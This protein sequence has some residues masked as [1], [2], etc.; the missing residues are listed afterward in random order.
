VKRDDF[1]SLPLRIALGIIYDIAR[2]PKL[3]DMPRPDV[4]KPPLYDTKL[5][6]GGGGFVWMS[7]MA[8]A[9]LEWWRNTKQKSADGNGD[10]ADRDRKSVAT[11]EKWI[12]WRVCFPSDTWSG[13]RGEDRVSGAPP[14]RNPTVQP[15]GSAERLEETRREERTARAR[16]D[17]ARRERRAR[18][19][20]ILKETTMSAEDETPE[21]E[22]QPSEPNASETEVLAKVTQL[23]RYHVTSKEI[24]EASG[25]RGDHVRHHRRLRARAQ[26][27]RALSHHASEDR[28]ASEGAE[29]AFP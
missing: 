23:V 24:R 1:V 9:D 5:S 10:Y 15:M 26:G 21:D 8:L 13:K 25:V 3:V 6:K 27:D 22:T 12:A 20:R 11:L 29:A 19:L 16:I 4:P 17:R 18:R 14:S 7:E 28:R 2:T